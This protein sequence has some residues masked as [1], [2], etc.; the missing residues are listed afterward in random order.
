MY[1]LKLVC[2]S[3]ELNLADWETLYPLVDC[4]E[5]SGGAVVLKLY[6]KDPE[7]ER[8][9]I[10]RFLHE[11]HWFNVRAI[12]YE[13]EM[14]KEPVWLG[15]KM[16]DGNNYE[17]LFGRGW[18]YKRVTGS[19]ALPAIVYSWSTSG[20]SDLERGGLLKEFTIAFQAKSRIDVDGSRIFAWET[21]TDLW[22]GHATGAIRTE[23]GIIVEEG[24]TNKIPNSDFENEADPDNGWFSGGASLTA[25]EVTDPDYV[26]NGFWSYQ[27]VEDGT[28]NR[29]W[30]A[31]VNVGNTNNHSLQAVCRRLD[32]GVVSAATAQLFYGAALLATTYTYLFDGWY[33]LRSEPFAGIVAAT[34]C[35]IYVMQGQAVIVDSFQLEEK[36][37]CSSYAY[38]NLG[39]GYTFSGAAHT[40]TSVRAAARL[41]YPNV[42]STVRMMLP[43]TGGTVRVHTTA[44]RAS[45]TYTGSNYL[46]YAGS[47]HLYYDGAFKW[48]DGTNTASTAAVAFASGDEIVVWASY[49]GGGIGLAV[50]VN[51]LIVGT[52]TVAAYAAPVPAIVYLGSDATPANHW[53]GIFREVQTW[54]EIFTAAE[55]T[56]RDKVGQGVGELPYLWSY[57]GAGAI[58]NQTDPADLSK[59]SWVE[60]G[61]VPGDY[62]AGC[63]L[64]IMNDTAITPLRIMVGLM[65]R[66]VPR[67]D[68]ASKRLRVGNHFRPWR[69][70]EAGA[71]TYDA[72]SST[73]ADAACIGGN[74]TRTSPSGTTDVLRV[75]IPICY[76]PEDMWTAVGSFRIIPRLYSATADRFLVRF[77]VTT[78]VRAGQYTHRFYVAGDSVWSWGKPQ[79]QVVFVPSHYIDPETVQELAPGDWTFAANGA[80][81]TLD[82]W[83]MAD[84]AAGSVDFDGVYLLPQDM[85]G[86]GIIEATTDW[87]EDRVVLIDSASKETSASTVHDANNERFLSGI[88]WSG[89]LLL[90]LKEPGIIVA[91]WLRSGAGYTWTI[92][93]AAVV[94][95]KYRPRYARLR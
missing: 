4:I 57:A 24:T 83:L 69:E 22:V 77:R 39:R 89:R 5:D 31:S 64:G 1:H 42:A 27:L 45:T 94:S 81:C 76:E 72:N 33:L 16:D 25:T 7:G 66:G 91:V 54:G 21:R 88:D 35:G 84:V 37:Y 26:Y 20:Y 48:T 65:R 51:G 14:V 43:R 61:N 52:G 74:K 86:Y 10:Q 46:I 40:T 55:R 18:L 82:Y 9:A 59:Q 67:T 87:P 58:V 56:A 68:I 47:M 90:P 60:V 34:A 13:H 75:R 30:Y 93:D 6:V 78:G 92:S 41:A 17:S 38:G 2:G 15:L 50:Y 29:T 36:A 71:A 79:N 63:K 3:K 49:G 70:A 12:E 73:V 53:S 44:R 11:L 8:E 80:Y 28:A 85:E 23:D 32:G 95:L 62:P 19:R